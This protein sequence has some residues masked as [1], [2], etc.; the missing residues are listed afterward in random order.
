MASRQNSDSGWLKIHHFKPDH[1]AHFELFRSCAGAMVH[2][3]IMALYF[4][5]LTVKSSDL[6]SMLLVAKSFWARLPFDIL[7]IVEHIVTFLL[8]LLLVVA[9][10]SNNS[11]RCKV[12]LICKFIPL[13]LAFVQFTLFVSLMSIW[14]AFYTLFIIYL[15]CEAHMGISKFVDELELENT[16]K[17]N[18]TR[19]EPD[20]D[21]EF[22]NSTYTQISEANTRRAMPSPPVRPAPRVYVN[23]NRRQSYPGY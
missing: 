5:T 2:I 11:R 19:T 16:K 15:H 21:F 12:W 9:T 13:G 6:L 7:A 23:P 10:N 1:I 14:F 8:A 17:R 18:R 20:N 3:A 22:A 4:D